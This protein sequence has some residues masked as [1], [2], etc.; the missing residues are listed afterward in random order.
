MKVALVGPAPPDRGG[1]AQQTSLLARALGPSLSGHYSYSRRYPRWLDPRRFDLAPSAERVPAAAPHIP[2]LDYARPASWRTAARALTAAGSE[3][4]IVA[5]WT[6]FWAIPVRA[7]VREVRRIDP[8]IPAVLLCHNVVEHETAWWKR[9]LSHG[10]FE[11]ANGFLVHSEEDRRRLSRIAPGRPALV[12]AHPV[13]ARPRPDRRA[14]REKLGVRR[15][16][17]LFLGLVRRYKGADLLLEAAARIC[18]ESDAEIAI[19]GEVFPDARFLSEQVEHSPLRDRLRLVDRYVTEE[20][21]D[22]WLAA[23]DVLVCP[24]RKVSGSGIAARAVA[25]GRPVVA[26]DLE[27]FHPFVTTETGRLFPAGDSTGL[28]EAVAEI[29]RRGI[30]AFQDGLA[31]VAAEH[32][33]EEYASALLSFCGGL[34]AE[35]ATIAG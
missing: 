35:S 24:Y 14:C 1:I 5:W 11:A 33:W 3:A 13:E 16:L 18:R 34:R 23:C 2:V 31:R 7:L 29:L 25:A 30:E 9:F 27:G 10:A 26:S 4:V 32:S 21:M 6:S 17:A 20:E 19:V 22:E 12:R 28:A 15:P 8:A